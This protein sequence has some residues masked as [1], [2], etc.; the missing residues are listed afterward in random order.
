MGLDLGSTSA[1]DHGMR[2][3]EIEFNKA[4]TCGKVRLRL[5]VI[6]TGSFES[7]GNLMSRL[8]DFPDP[9]RIE[10]SVR[11]RQR[12][13]RQSRLASGEGGVMLDLFFIPEDCV[14]KFDGADQEPGET[15]SITKTR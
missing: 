5:R 8:R 3:N 11:L 4:K 9:C 15:T 10:P 12:L 7:P 6:T 14:A 13:C 2:P 1:G